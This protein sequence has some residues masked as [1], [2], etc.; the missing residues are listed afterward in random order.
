LGWWSKDNQYIF[1]IWY[2]PKQKYFLNQ[3]S[4]RTKN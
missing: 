2:I 4:K 3:E 1:L